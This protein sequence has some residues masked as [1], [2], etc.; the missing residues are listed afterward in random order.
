MTLID[1]NKRTYLCGSFPLLIVG[2]REPMKVSRSLGALTRR[3]IEFVQA[4]VE[5]LDLDGRTVTTS[6]GVR[7][8]DY[9]VVAPGARY[10]WDAVPGSS[11]AYSFYSIETAR[12]LRRRLATFRKGRVVIAVSG[13][14]YKCPPAP[15]EAAMVLDWHFERR[16]VRKDIDIH[17]YMAEPAPMAVAG[18]EASSRIAADLDQRGITLHPSATVTEVAAN[19]REAAFSDGSS[20]R[21]DLVITIP[22]HRVPQFVAEGGLAEPAGWLKVDPATLATGRPEVYAVGDATAVMMANGRPLPKAGVFAASAGETAATN[23]AAMVADAEPATF[24]GIG[25]C[26]LAYSGTEAGI[27]RGAFLAQGKPDVEY[28]P[29]SARGYKSKERFE[30]DWKRFR[31]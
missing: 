13:V 3:G 27:V 10:D 21:A 6:A 15:F 4:D 22:I 29:G 31:I 2:E 28:L 30:E 19:G 23:I 9:L 26:Y 24:P 17:V 14:P 12:K 18:P 8:Y 11:G 16:E 25:H 5:S 20:M 1:R 7:E